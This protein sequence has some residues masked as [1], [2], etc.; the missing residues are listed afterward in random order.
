M[1]VQTRPAP[2]LPEQLA[3]SVVRLRVVVQRAAALQAVRQALTVQPPS[4][5]RPSAP[6]FSAR[7]AQQVL[8]M[9]QQVFLLR[10]AELRDGASPAVRQGRSHR[11]LRSFPVLPAL[12]QLPQR[13]GDGVLRHQLERARAQEPAARQP[14]FRGGDGKAPRQVW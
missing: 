11:L 3:V 1:E 14:K 5:Q 2:A 13:D 12:V 6:Q 8:Q 4:V 7:A 10:A 9:P